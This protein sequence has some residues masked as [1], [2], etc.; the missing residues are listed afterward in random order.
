MS[1][2]SPNFSIESALAPDAPL[3]ALLS[4]RDNPNLAQAS[5][6][7]LF[8]VVSR[9]RNLTGNAQAFTAELNKESEKVKP[10]KRVTKT[11]RINAALD[12]I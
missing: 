10:T 4:L 3:V 1:N 8:A 6:E 2:E 7:E 5:D 12:A 9:C 11:A